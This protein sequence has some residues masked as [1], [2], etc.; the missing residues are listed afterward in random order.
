MSQVKGATFAFDQFFN[1][2]SFD[3]IIELGTGSGTFSLFFSFYCFV[4]NADFC[5]FDIKETKFKDKIENLGGKV[6]SD[7][8]MENKDYII[9]L[10]SKTKRTLMLCDNGNKP[11]EVNTFS[12]YMKIDD[13]I[14]AHDFFY[15]RKKTD[16]LW[17]CEI[18]NDRINNENLEYK[19]RDIFDPVFWCCLRRYK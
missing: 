15:D 7:D 3:Q 13:Y 11:L 8:I 4:N 2:E 17:N 16:N 1:L 6:V 5:T 14:M 12:K 10:L 18:S 19:Y 9:S